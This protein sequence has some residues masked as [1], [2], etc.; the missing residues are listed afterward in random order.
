MSCSAICCAS[1]ISF[2]SAELLPTCRSPSPALTTV[3]ITVVRASS[4]FHAIVMALHD[5]L[6]TN[7]NTD[8]V[9][10]P[11]AERRAT[12]EMRYVLI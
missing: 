10:I 2:M 4:F 5:P 12:L 11:N 7:P 3:L 6:T 1:Y 9:V 8:S